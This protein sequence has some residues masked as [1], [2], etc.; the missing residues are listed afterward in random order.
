MKGLDKYLNDNNI[1]KKQFWITF[2]AIAAIGGFA[3]EYDRIFPPPPMT[4]ELATERLCEHLKTVESVPAYTNTLANK[5]FARM[6]IL[7]G[8]NISP[9]DYNRKKTIDE[10]L[11]SREISKQL[12]PGYTYLGQLGINPMDEEGIL[13]VMSNI[14][15]VCENLEKGIKT[16]ETTIDNN[17]PTE[18]Y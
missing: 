18:N 8:S 17:T 15:T 13:N 11:I 5:Y 14:S 3:K 2:L 6:Y 9:E 10:T 12:E 7:E 4:K 16:D 1:T